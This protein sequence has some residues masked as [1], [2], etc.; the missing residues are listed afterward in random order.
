MSETPVFDQVVAELEHDPL[1]GRDTETPPTEVGGSSAPDPTPGQS[2][3]DPAFP[4]E[5][6]DAAPAARAAAPTVPDAAGTTNSPEPAT[7]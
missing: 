6:L 7:S 4:A 5:D 1:A 2:G 3:A